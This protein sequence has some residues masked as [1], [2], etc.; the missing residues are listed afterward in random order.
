MSFEKIFDL[1]AVVYFYFCNMYAEA[2]TSAIRFVAKRKRGG[3]VNVLVNTKE[4]EGHA[5]IRMFLMKVPDTNTRSHQQ[6]QH[7]PNISFVY[8]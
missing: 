2:R 4:N 6:Q 5:G 8:V 7:P 1:K 3:I